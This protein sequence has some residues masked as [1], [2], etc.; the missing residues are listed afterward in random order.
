[1]FLIFRY[2]LVYKKGY[3]EFSEVESSVTTKL[4]GV[5]FTNF[6]NDFFSKKISHPEWYRRVWD[7]ADYVVPPSVS[8]LTIL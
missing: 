1:M 3:Q 6:S 8:N 2:V 5:I 7:V 4:K